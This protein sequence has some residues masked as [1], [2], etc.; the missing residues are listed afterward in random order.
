M[1]KRFKDLIQRKDNLWYVKYAR[2]P[3][4]GVNEEFHDNGQLKWKGN[5]KDGKEHG[6]WETYWDDGQLRS[7]ENY[8]NGKLH[9]SLFN[10]HQN[11][12]IHIWEWYQ[13]D[14]RLILEEYHK[15][16][17]L[18][19][20]E[21]EKTRIREFYEQY[22]DTYGLLQTYLSGREEYKSTTKQNHGLYEE[23]HKN[24]KLCARGEYKNGNPDGPF[25]I[26]DEEGNFT[27]IKTYKNGKLVK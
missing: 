9:G 24:G 16:G 13:D 26:F 27:E 14:Q 10:F 3:F 8:K 23:F 6:L 11:G 21:N 22:V 20:R 7:K 2:V 17:P 18:L 12:K 1:S 25:D 4:T 5:Y 15:E 19:Y